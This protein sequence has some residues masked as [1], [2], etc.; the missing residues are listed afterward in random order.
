MHDESPLDNPAW[1]ALTGPDARVAE[2][3][4]RAARFDPAISVFTALDDV[5]V[6]ATAAWDDVAA[7]VGPG[8]VAVFPG[9]PLPAPPG[10]RVW[11]DLPGLQLVGDAFEPREDPEV[12]P[13][14]AE[15]VD[16]MV[17]L[18]ERTKPGPFTARTHELGGYRGI[19]RDGVLLAMAGERMHPPG[20]TEISAVCTDPSA[21]GQGLATRVMRAVAAGI[22][23]RGETPFLHVATENE[24]ATRLYQSLGFRVRRPIDFVGLYAPGPVV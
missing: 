4:G 17:D 2:R 9:S 23:D 8:G 21:R 15:H 6:D 14:G 19:I 13:L 10:W 12:V 24:A 5:T 1:S 7:L 20:F 18:V 11:L 16:A 3:H 22:A